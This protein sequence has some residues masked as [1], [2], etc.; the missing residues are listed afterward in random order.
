MIH[1]TRIQSKYTRKL[2]DEAIRLQGASSRWMLTKILDNA[3]DKKAIEESFKRID[4]YT[5]DFQVCDSP[6]CE[7]NFVIS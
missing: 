2:S 7:T 6:T 3:E 4:E 1:V 5:K